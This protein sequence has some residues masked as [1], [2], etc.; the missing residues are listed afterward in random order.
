M[1]VAY[2]SSNTSVYV[3]GG[4]SFDCVVTK[5]SGLAIG[6]LMILQ[7]QQQSTL[8]VPSFSGWTLIDSG[9]YSFSTPSLMNNGIFTKVADASDVAATNFTFTASS[10]SSTHIAALYRIT[11]MGTNPIIT[12]SGVVV[13]STSPSITGLTQPTT[14][15]LLLML[16]LGSNQGSGVSNYAIAN[17][18]PTWNEIYDISTTI[19][20]DNF[21]ASAWAV[22]SP[23]TA[24]GNVSC[25]VADSGS[26]PDTNI[27]LICIQ[28]PQPPVVTTQAISDID[29]TTAT[30]NGIVVSDSGYVITERGVVLSTVPAPTVADLKFLSA[31]T[32]GAFTAPIINLD[33]NTTYYVRAFAT[34]SAGTTYGSE[35]NFTT[36]SIAA[37][38]VYKDING[39]DGAV[40]AVQLYVG[41]TTGTVTVKLGSTGTSQVIAAGAG[42]T[43]FQ[44]TY[45]G[46]NGL[47]IEASPTFDGYIDNVYHVLVVGSATI[48]WSLDNL[49]NVYPINSSVTFKRIEDQSF[50]RFRIYRYLDVQFKDLDAYVTVVLKKEQNENL[51]TS[52]K[53]FLVSNTS[54]DI[55]PFIDKKISTLFKSQAVRVAFSNNRLNE[56][57]TI[58][59]FIIRGTEQPPKTFDKSKIISIS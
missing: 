9:S 41:G 26:D 15:N 17:S 46:L 52:T 34:N 25:S 55:L 22:R 21:M 16:I 54:E 40:Y 6:D 5:P 30:G 19:G 1:A 3:N 2:A 29:L 10:T 57:F 37:N 8:S 39:V 12:T 14:D 32:T 44:G 13:D 36:L 28:P 18:N 43:T 38:I 53:E 42:T 27:F 48:D 4:L 20:A 7:F 33:A 59:Q 49:T 23:A 50:N 31:G 58:C 47:T 45:G 56:R 51:A 35:V 24:T 11:G